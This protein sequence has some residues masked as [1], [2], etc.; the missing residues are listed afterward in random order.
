MN[1]LIHSVNKTHQFVGLSIREAMKKNQIEGIVL[2]MERHGVRKINPSKKT[3]LHKE[4]LL[5]L[6]VYKTTP[7]NT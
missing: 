4:D 5:I 1:K 7:L 2:G 3:I 6:L